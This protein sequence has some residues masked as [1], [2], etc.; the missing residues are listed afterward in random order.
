MVAYHPRWF[1]DLAPRWCP[2]SNTDHC[3]PWT[4]DACEPEV[5]SGLP[6]ELR[7]DLTWKKLKYKNALGWWVLIYILDKI[8]KD[9][10][11]ILEYK[12]LEWNCNGLNILKYIIL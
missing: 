1:S 5:R 7:T 12:K 4:A 11:L 10:T 9:Y 6:P 8:P 2:T 3:R